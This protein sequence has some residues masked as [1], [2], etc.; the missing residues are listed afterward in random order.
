[1]RGV[2]KWYQGGDLNS[3][4]RAYESPA[5]PLSYPGTKTG[6][7]HPSFTPRIASR[8]FAVQIKWSRSRTSAAFFYPLKIALIHFTAPPLAGGVERVVG[9]QIRLL[10]ARGHTVSLACF[11][12]GGM[13]SGAD[14]HIPLSRAASADEF[15]T[16]LGSALSGTDVILMHNVCTMPFVPALTEALRRLPALVPSARWICWVHDLALGDPDYAALRSAPHAKV[17]TLPCAEWEYVAVSDLRA[18]EVEELLEVPCTIV[19]NGVDPGFTLQLSPKIAALAEAS[20]WW[21]ADAVFLHPARILPRKTL[22]LG[23]Q[24]THA[25]RAQGFRLQILLTGAEDLQTPAHAAYAKYLKTLT[26]SLKLQDAVFFLGDTMEIGPK[27]FCDFYQIADALLFPGQREGFGLPVLEAGVFGKLVFC[28]DCEP[29][30]ILPG[31]VTYDPEL[32]VG[33]LAAWFISRIRERETIMARRKILRDYRWPSI[34]HNH[35]APLLSRL[36][37]LYHP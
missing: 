37:L 12:G 32:P 5:L 4:P 27:E 7:K 30:S 3:R 14:T 29:L 15:S 31:A 18:R 19:P 2:P 6:G 9:E 13:A 1:M 23:I 11:E 33:E 25:A 16:Y 34:Y 28:P 17:F 10:R 21:E 35:I 26:A 20:G 24:L 36:P 22:E 8:E